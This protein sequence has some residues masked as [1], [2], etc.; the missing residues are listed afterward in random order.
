[1]NG[2]LGY[3]CSICGAE[4]GPVEV[5]YTCPKDGGNLDV[6]LDLDSLRTRYQPSDIAS[7]S[8]ASLWRYLPLLPVGEFPGDA[9]PLHAAGGTPVFAL[10]RIGER[11]GAKQLWLK[12]E[13]RNPTGS[14]K[15]RASAV[16]V[17]RAREIQAD[18]IVISAIV[19][20]NE[21]INCFRLLTG[22]SSLQFLSTSITGIQI[23]PVLDKLFAVAPA[24]VNLTTVPQG[25]KI[26]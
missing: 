21:E 17:A 23:M 20:K 12:D 6:V 18:V 26:Q 3:R 4:Y 15:D 14:F 8:D 7:R 1:M 19:T 9:T 13:S 2:F 24:Q 22:R 25:R 16:V 11:L 5:T 10:R